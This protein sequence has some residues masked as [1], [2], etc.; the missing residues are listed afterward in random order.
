LSKRTVRG[1]SS[2]R[3]E[4]SDATRDGALAQ[5]PIVTVKLSAASETRERMRG[6]VIV[7]SVIGIGPFGA[8]SLS[9]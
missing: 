3:I 5:P 8:L 1:S 2:V 9:A 6:V 4:A 7:S